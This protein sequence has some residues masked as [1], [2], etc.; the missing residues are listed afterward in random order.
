MI[1]PAWLDKTGGAEIELE[2]DTSGK[3]NICCGSYCF[4]VSC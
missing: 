1:C 4:Y 2:H 3:R